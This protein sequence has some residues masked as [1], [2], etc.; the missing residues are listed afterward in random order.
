MIIKN[1]Q[2]NEET[3]A[4]INK[5]I[6]ADINASIAFKLSRIIKE[7]SSILEDKNKMEQTIISRYAEKDE[8][9]NIIQGKDKDGNPI[10]GSVN[11]IDME[12]FNSDISDLLNT[13]N[14]I[15][16]EKIKFEDMKLQTAKVKDLMLLDF[17]FE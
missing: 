13:E 7:I 1:S 5:L 15:P 9:G 2:L 12:S 8:N 14:D 3:I 17:L 16:Y 10:Q 4:S 6:V 11:I